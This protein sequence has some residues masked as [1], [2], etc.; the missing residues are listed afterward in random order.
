[1]IETTINIHHDNF[2]KIS[3]ASMRTGKSHR[4]IIVALLMLIM[5]DCGAFQREFTAVK[6]QEDDPAGEWHHFHIKYRVDENEFVT[7]LRKFCK[8]SVSLFL[9]IAVQKYITLLIGDTKKSKIMNNYPRFCNYVLHRELIDGVISWHSY[10]GFPHEHLK[11][12]LL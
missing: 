3:D 4:N 10:W 8:F 2:A 11:T 1:M 12:L 9:A 5:A 7:D 6:Y